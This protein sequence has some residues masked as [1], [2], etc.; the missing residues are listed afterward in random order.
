MKTSV[1]FSTI[2]YNTK[3]FLLCQLNQLDVDFWFAIYHYPEKDELKGHFHLYVEPT[4][5]IDTDSFRKALE[6]FVPNNDKPLGCLPC[7]KSK[8]DD[9]LL[10]FLHDKEY[11]AN[12]FLSREYHYKLS[13]CITNSFEFL[14]ERYSMI[15][16]RKYCA[17]SKFL[18]FV[19]QGV[20]FSSLVAQGYIPIQQMGQY[21]IFYSALIEDFVFRNNNLSHTPLPDFLKHEHAKQLIMSDK[22]ICQD[23][24]RSLDGPSSVERKT[25]KTRR[26]S[27]A[28]N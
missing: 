12:K 18:E 1:P 16:R 7:R 26:N 3:E 14:Q 15:D 28:K 23:L 19:E 2:S 4:N 24:E 5:R 8:F 10:Y 20:P 22:F 6:E 21:K 25:D 27:P 9:A 13:D 17:K 11:L